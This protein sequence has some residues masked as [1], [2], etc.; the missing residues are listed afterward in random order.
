MLTSSNTSYF[1]IK[2]LRQIIE[3]ER[4]DHEKNIFKLQ[5]ELNNQRKNE[6]SVSKHMKKG[7]VE[8]DSFSSGIVHVAENIDANNTRNQQEINL[9]REKKEGHVSP[10]E[11]KPLT[12]SANEVEHS[13]NSNKKD[14]NEC[15]SKFVSKVHMTTVYNE[16]VPFLSTSARK[17]IENNDIDC[18]ISS[19]KLLSIFINIVRI[20]HSLR[21]RIVSDIEEKVRNSRILFTINVTCCFY[22]IF[23]KMTKS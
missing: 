21:N 23:L 8:K 3:Q 7:K 10:G 9:V 20:E 13:K 4:I 1:R 17:E 18:F 12:L 2:S 5:T 22:H 19:E 11:V 14:T 6:P 16:L 15:D